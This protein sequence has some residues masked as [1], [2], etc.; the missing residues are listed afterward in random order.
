MRKL[1]VLNKKYALLVL[2]LFFCL[3]NITGEEKEFIFPFFNKVYNFNESKKTLTVAMDSPHYFTKE[4]FQRG[5]ES[6]LIDGN[7]NKLVR[8]AKG[9]LTPVDIG[10][11]SNIYITE[12]YLLKFSSAFYENGFKGEVYKIGKAS[13]LTLTGSFDIDLFV[14]DYTIIGDKLI[15]TGSTQNNFS[16]KIYRIDLDKCLSEEI[17]SMKKESTFLKVIKGENEI[18]FYRSSRKV[19]NNKVLYKIT[20]NELANLEA[21]KIKLTEHKVVTKAKT[22]FFGKGFARGNRLYI[23]AIDKNADITLT[24]VSS[25]AETISETVLPTGVYNVVYNDQNIVYFIGFN[26]YKNSGAFQ[27]AGF[28]LDSRKVLYYKELSEKK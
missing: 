13:E 7:K 25:K 11:F 8:L 3:V 15:L 28:D 16:N 14:S 4:Y 1:K 10:D 27:L 26:Y 6:Y 21:K 17:F 24:E 2:C 19:D 23:P 5:N 20:T 18:T 9:Q 12:N 22:A